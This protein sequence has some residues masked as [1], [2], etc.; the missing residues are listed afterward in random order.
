M[1]W[2]PDMRLRLESMLCSLAYMFPALMAALT[3]HHVCDPA[4]WNAQ[5]D[6]TDCDGLRR[7]AAECVGSLCAWEFL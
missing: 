4:Q 1:E 7:L 2:V 3:K 6:D 5:H